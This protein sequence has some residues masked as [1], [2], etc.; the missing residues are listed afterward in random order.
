LINSTDG[1]D[2]IQIYH[3]N[4]NAYCKTTDGEFRVITNE[5]TNTHTILSVRGK[6]AGDGYIYCY[7]GAEGG[8][9][10]VMRAT[11]NIGEVLVDTD[12]TAFWIQSTADA[13]IQTFF[14]AAEGETEE[15]EIYGYRTGDSKRSLEIGVGVDAADTASFD[16]VS[17]YRFDGTVTANTGFD[18]NGSAGV[19]GTLELD[20]GSTEKITLVFTGG[21]L[22]SRTVAATTGSVLADW[23]D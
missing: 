23:T 15:L 10:Y 11:N 14:N 5:G 9:R 12:P 2:Q 18:V 13:P 19:S 3:D 16:G 1:S 20:D 6:G 17:E 21:I 8:S 4:N 7:A 22:T